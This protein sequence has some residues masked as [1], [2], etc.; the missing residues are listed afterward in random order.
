MRENVHPG[1]VL[2]VDAAG[3]IPYYS[4]LRSIDMF[5]LN[6]RHIARVVVPRMGSGEVGH[7][8]YDPAY[9]YA[10]NPDWIAVWM[11]RNG[12]P[13]VGLMRWPEIENY[14]LYLVVQTKNRSLPWMQ[15][16]DDSVDISALWD[17]GYTYGLWKRDNRPVLQHS[18]LDIQTASKYG[19]WEWRPRMLQGIEYWFSRTPGDSLTLDVDH[20][21]TW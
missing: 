1:S 13:G 19:S 10:Q 6:D 8:K 5:G 3:A 14:S 18:E 17:N 15:I 2:A 20:G 9:V 4:G 21:R 11:N 12:E 7:E 16:V